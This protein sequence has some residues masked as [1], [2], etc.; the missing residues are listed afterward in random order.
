MQQDIGAYLT[1]GSASATDSVIQAMR[2]KMATAVDARIVS[3]VVK[4]VEI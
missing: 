1:A 3:N 4:V 2:L